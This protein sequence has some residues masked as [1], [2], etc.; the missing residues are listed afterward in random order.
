MHE[1]LKLLSEDRKKSVKA[2]EM[3]DMEELEIAM[4][5][6]ESHLTICRQK[7]CNELE[8]LLSEMWF[9]HMNASLYA[10]EGMD[11]E[12]L[13]CCQNARVFAEHIYQRIQ[14]ML[15]EEPSEQLLYDAYECICIWCSLWY[16]LVQQHRITD[17]MDVVTMATKRMQIL[18]VYIEENVSLCTLFAEHFVNFAS[19]RSSCG[20]VTGAMESL[21]YAIDLFQKLHKMTGSSYHKVMVIRTETLKLVFAMQL[22]T[23]SLEEISSLE[24][25]VKSLQFQRCERLEEQFAQEIQI[26]LGMSRA[27]LLEMKDRFSEA[28]KIF[29][30]MQQK[31]EE[32][33]PYF[34]KESENENTFI[35]KVS[36]ETAK[37]LKNY[38]IVCREQI[39]N[40]QAT[41]GKLEDAAKTYE[42]ILMILGKGDLT[43]TRIEQDRL[44]GRFYVMLGM[45]YGELEEWT[46]GSFYFEKAEETWGVLVTD[47]GLPQDEESYENAKRERLAFTKRMERSKNKSKGFFGRLFGK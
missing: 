20:D 13:E 45:I 23:V 38:Q 43:V 32:I 46:K 21:Q 3:L 24:Q 8:Y 25:K 29:K 19:I 41:E 17:A 33:A 16:I 10:G 1:I 5:S 6:W 30:Q 22:R 34:I 35:R 15:M 9:E 28:E 4:R 31:A 26:M 36:K 12:A 42:E 40:C 47:T 39:G 18:L 14:D 7:E 11:A 27:F 44:I 37:K 2:Y